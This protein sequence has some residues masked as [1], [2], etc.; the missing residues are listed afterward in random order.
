MRSVALCERSLTVSVCIVLMYCCSCCSCSV[1]ALTLSGRVLLLWVIRL[2]R[3]AY[4]FLGQ[5]CC[6]LTGTTPPGPATTTTKTTPS[7]ATSPRRANQ[8]ETPSPTA[9]KSQHKKTQAVS[10]DLLG[11]WP[12][13]PRGGEYGGVLG[14]GFGGSSTSVNSPPAAGFDSMEG[15]V[16]AGQRAVPHPVVAVMNG[17]TV[18]ILLRLKHAAMF[19]DFQVC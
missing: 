9:A 12:S 7:G 2:K 19:E 5:Y 18:S 11:A 14:G 3:S 13:N 1:S 15:G 16:G 6:Q 10:N 4:W 17:A 8:S